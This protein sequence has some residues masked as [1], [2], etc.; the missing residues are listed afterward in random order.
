MTDAESLR[1]VAMLTSYFRQELSDETAV[2]W[3]RELRSFEPVDGME[4]AQILG[5]MGRFMPSLA[6]FVDA[7]R[8]CRNQ[9]L[10]REVPA[11][12]PSHDYRGRPYTLAEHL[13][14]HPDDDAKVRGLALKHRDENMIYHTLATVLRGEVG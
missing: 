3:A 8:D 12:P 5:T 1:L 4:A 11:L 6:E 10:K 14:T 13:A 2:L 9:R 7:V